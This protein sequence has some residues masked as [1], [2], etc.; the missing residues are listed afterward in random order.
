MPAPNPE[1]T[2][3]PTEE[4]LASVPKDRGAQRDLFLE[5]LDEPRHALEYGGVNG[6]ATIKGIPTGRIGDD[7]YRSK[8]LGVVM[9]PV[10][11]L[12]RDAVTIDTAVR[13][14]G[15]SRI[16]LQRAAQGGRLPVLK[17]GPD[18][19]PY[20]VRLRDVVTYLVTMWTERRARREFNEGMYLG[21]PEWL[22]R[23][24]AESWP[25]NK[26]YRPGNWEA[27]VVNI[28]RGGRPK[29]YSPGRAG[30]NGYSKNGVKLG[31][32]PKIP[33]Q[34]KAVPPE[35]NHPQAVPE[36]PPATPTTPAIQEQTDPTRLPKWHPQWRRPGT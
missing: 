19:A 4:E 17:T 35:G 26:P 20:V 12:M 24:V 30:F 2:V 14:L 10:P 32:P 9:E 15:V 34:E 8:K 1:Y 28:S 18:N 11:V 7:T 27:R 21:F 29:G 22:A 25:D 33:V 13:L 36:S 3:E 16:T 31:R 23:E 6:E 5:A